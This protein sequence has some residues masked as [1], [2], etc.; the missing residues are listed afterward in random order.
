MRGRILDARTGQ[1]VPGAQVRYEQLPNGEQ[2]GQVAAATG[3]FE[4]ALPAGQQY[5]FRAE[6]EGYVAASDN[7]D[8]SAVKTGGEVSRDLYL[9]P[10]VGRLAALP[11]A[12][13]PAADTAGN[14]SLKL[15]PT[16]AATPAPPSLAAPAREEARLVLNNVF[17][18]QG[19]PV[20]LPA[21]FPELKRLAQTLK[22]NSSL[23]IRLEGHTDNQ[24]D[25][26]KNQLLSEQRVAEIKKYLIRQQVA[27]DRLETIGYGPTRPVAP[28]DV[29]ANRRRNRRVEFAILQ[30]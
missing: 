6:A 16:T 29:E 20:L 2:A 14:A 28:N 30:R 27:A 15:K 1:L 17:F 22:G 5:G 9:L 4:I 26:G 11:V 18:E 23:R 13:R 19:K 24:G 7:L 21:S 3:A 10:D 12:P 25:A 8:L